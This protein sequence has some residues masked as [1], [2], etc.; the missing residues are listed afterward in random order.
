MLSVFQKQINCSAVH[1]RGVDKAGWRAILPHTI[2]IKLDEMK[3][4]KRDEFDAKMKELVFVDELLPYINEDVI[5][6]GMLTRGKEEIGTVGF[7]VTATLDV[8]E[9]AKE[10]GCNALVVHHGIKFADKHLDR[11][12]YGR[13]TWLVKND[14]TLWQSHF[15]IDAHPELG[16][17]AQILLALGIKDTEPYLFHGEAPWGRVGEFE[18]ARPFSEIIDQLYPQLSSE[19]TM[20]D[21]GKPDVKRVV[22]VSGK[23]APYDSDMDLLIEDGV[24]LYITGEVHEW[25]RNCFKEAGINF[26]AGGHYHTETFG[27]RAVQERVEQE[28]GLKTVWLDFP[29]PV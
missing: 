3:T 15:A 27:V 19:L 10:K 8:F 22:C 25:N 28:M 21:Y 6:N 4:I 14:I 12:S 7:A 13:F 24:D 26:L 9:A 20:Y 18:E 17:N 5:Y 16:N 23:G 29:N 1:W 11:V 2:F